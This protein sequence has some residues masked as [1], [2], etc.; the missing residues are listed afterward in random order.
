[1][2]SLKPYDVNAIA[3]YIIQCL[4]V[5]DEEMNLINLK[6]QKLLHYPQAWS[7]GINKGRF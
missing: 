7:L 3:D 6:S 1:M 2:D 5:D 4:N